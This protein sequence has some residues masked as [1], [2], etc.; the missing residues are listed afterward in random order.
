MGKE[1]LGDLGSGLGPCEQFA[2][3]E[4]RSAVRLARSGGAA[5]P[6]E[7]ASDML[8]CSGGAGVPR[9]TGLCNA[10]VREGAIPRD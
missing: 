8:G 7:V 9:V 1:W 3:E 5:G 2:V 6:S 4:V 10:I